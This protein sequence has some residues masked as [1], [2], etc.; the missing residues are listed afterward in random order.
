MNPELILKMKG[1]KPITHEIMNVEQEMIKYINAAAK[2][3]SAKHYSVGTTLFLINLF[4][5]LLWELNFPVAKEITLENYYDTVC[6]S[7]LNDMPKTRNQFFKTLYNSYIGNNTFDDILIACLTNN[8][9]YIIYS[10]NDFSNNMKF[11]T[12]FGIKDNPNIPYCVI[13]NFE[14]SELFSPTENLYSI[15]Y[16]KR[17]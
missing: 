8:K 2:R 5:C 15:I 14:Q 3:K 4:P 17:N 11:Y 6:S 12:Y 7:I 16:A 9:R 10:I 1:Q 13:T